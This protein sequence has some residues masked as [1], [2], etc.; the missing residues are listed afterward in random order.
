MAA[1]YEFFPTKQSH[2]SAQIQ[3][4][5]HSDFTLILPTPEQ[6]FQRFVLSKLVSQ[7]MTRTYIKSHPQL[8]QTWAK[9]CLQ[10]RSRERYWFL[11]EKLR[12]FL[13][14]N[15]TISYTIDG[16]TLS[17]NKYRPSFARTNVLSRRMCTTRNKL[18]M[19][20]PHTSQMKKVSLSDFYPPELRLQTPDITGL[21]VIFKSDRS[22]HRHRWF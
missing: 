10:Y 3:T 16:P 13:R 5:Y 14:V 17:S 22:L 7:N 21:V 8:R 19:P 6:T 2:L 4:H 1:I 12:S 11:N 9:I 15:T 20:F 18:S